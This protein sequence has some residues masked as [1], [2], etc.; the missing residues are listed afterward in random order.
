M[1]KILNLSDYITEANGF[2]AK[3]EFVKPSLSKAADI[4][5]R[6][7]N[8]K[9]GLKFLKFPFAVTSIID[10]TEN[11]GIMFYSDK[12]AKAFRV[13]DNTSGAAGII[14]SLQFFSDAS[15]PQAD[16]SL[17]AGTPKL[18][19]IK[20]L[21]EFVRLVND[22][23]YQKEVLA[24]SLVTEA[25]T[26][27][28]SSSELKTV[29]DQLSNGASVR[30]IALE[31][32]VPYRQ[33]SRIKKSVPVVNV[34]SPAEKQ[35]ELTLNDKVKY[36]EETMED[37]YQI[38]RRVGAGAF[39]SLFIS[40]RAGTG[41]T[42][43]VER[44]LKDEGLTEG[45]DYVLVSGAASVIM[46]YKKFYQYRN[47]TLVFDDCDAVFRDENGRNLMKAA[48]D[49]KAVRK[50]SYLKKTTA[51][52]DPKDFENDPE[53]EFNALE[54][55]IV[56]NTFE[57]AGRVIF[58]SNLSK[59]KAD[60]DGAIRSR[61]ILI[62]VNPDDATLME[63]MKTLLPYLEPTDMALKDKEEIFDFMK[64]AK[65]ISMRT[66]V[67]AAGFKMAGL[68]NWKRMAKRYL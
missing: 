64:E 48:L 43:N 66:F 22:T 36:L 19:V 51:V 25:K 58:I 21:D 18:P 15:K 53:G 52:F 63:R 9:T 45:D 24:E 2:A 32:D 23:A 8:K 1:T 62:D 3:V 56:P 10:G 61:S 27:P 49:T 39:T 29:S 20:L 11:T 37:I 7:V 47:G 46:M 12:G 60:P 4:V 34:E 44:A 38:S 59:D 26:R 17:E 30:S 67:K 41:K 33:I 14:G 16:F 31:L 40:G 13:S 35:N 28:L 57:F 6:F 42:Y 5:A 55:G 54:N 65:D 68:G 50:I